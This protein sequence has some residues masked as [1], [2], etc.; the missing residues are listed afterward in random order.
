[1]VEL[2]SWKSLIEN[3]RK[4]VKGYVRI[5]IP[6]W[7]SVKNPPAMQETEEMRVQS[8]GRED[9]LEEEMATHSSILAR[10][11]PWTKESGKLQSV[12]LQRVRH[13]WTTEHTYK[14]KWITSLTLLHFMHELS[15]MNRLA[16]LVYNSVAEG[17]YESRVIQM[18]GNYSCCIRKPL[19]RHY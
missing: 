12:G 7:L 16:H 2:T 11:I 15:A 3:R 6:W 18:V 5:W 14:K 13:D 8:L 1:M 4:K 9:C 10:K 17:C 19:W